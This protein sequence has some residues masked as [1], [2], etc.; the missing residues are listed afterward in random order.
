MIKSFCNTNVQ[1]QIDI[2]LTG[3]ID[4]K[5][6]VEFSYVSITKKSSRTYSV[7]L[8]AESSRSIGFS[9]VSKWVIPLPLALLHWKVWSDK[10]RLPSPVLRHYINSNLVS[11][12]APMETFFLIPLS[13]IQITQINWFSYCLTKFIKDIISQSFSQFNTLIGI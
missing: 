13:E 12:L 8:Q 2:F 3:I 6:L 10:H 5:R 9:K 1:Q 11:F 4:L 7:R